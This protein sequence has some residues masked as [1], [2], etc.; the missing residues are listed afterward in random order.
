MN[1]WYWLLWAFALLFIYSQF[2]FI[3]IFYWVWK[4]SASYIQ[5]IILVMF[6][7][8]NCE[9]ISK[10]LWVLFTAQEQQTLDKKCLIL[11][12]DCLTCTQW[13]NSRRHISI[14]SLHSS[15]LKLIVIQVFRSVFDS[16]WSY[17]GWW[18]IL[19]IYSL[20]GV[21]MCKTKDC[22]WYN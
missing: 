15:L 5:W 11:C 4:F 10:R 2:I 6:G 18:L 19:H 16:W 22:L 1:K 8:L 9:Y 17:N 3:D 20:Q 12:F 13:H 7:W 21:W 14:F